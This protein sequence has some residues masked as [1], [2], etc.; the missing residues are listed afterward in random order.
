MPEFRSPQERV[1][2]RID[3]AVRGER[4]AQRRVVSYRVFEAD[5]EPVDRLIPPHTRAR[6]DMPDEDEVAGRMTRSGAPINAAAQMVEVD[7][8]VLAL[9]AAGADAGTTGTLCQQSR[10]IDGW[11][12]VAD[13][14]SWARPGVTG[15]LS[16]FLGTRKIGGVQQMRVQY[17]LG[18]LRGKVT[19]NA[20][21]HYEG[22]SPGD[23]RARVFLVPFTLEDGARR[24]LV[25]VFETAREVG[26]AASPMTRRPAA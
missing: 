19:V 2:E 8:G 3:A 24:Y 26:D 17:T 18:H 10:P 5:A 22:P 7:S 6:G 16:G 4:G 1:Q 23:G 9:I 21:I 15:T 11:P 20:Q 14:Q 12:R 25:V 13:S